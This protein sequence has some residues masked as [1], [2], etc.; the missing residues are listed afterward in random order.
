VEVV[1]EFRVREG[2]VGFEVADW[3]V[4]WAVVVLFCCVVVKGWGGFGEIGGGPESHGS[5]A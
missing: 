4:G 3:D 2:M 5:K 1:L